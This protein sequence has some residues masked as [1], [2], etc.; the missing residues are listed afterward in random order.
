MHRNFEVSGEVSG[1]DDSL[2]SI[3]VSVFIR[4]ES[5]ET[6]SSITIAVAVTNISSAASISI[7]MSNW[8]P[9]AWADWYV[10]S[11]CS[12]ST[13]DRS[14]NLAIAISA[15][16]MIVSDEITSLVYQTIV[17][18]A[19][20]FTDIFIAAVIESSKSDQ[21]LVL[22]AGWLLAL[23]DITDAVIMWTA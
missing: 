16:L 3:F 6:D 13:R 19:K 11:T 4:V 12:W 7:P 23:V 2:T 20:I 8:L 10:S 22:Q 14:V 5:T 18:T 9:S 1:E 21:T 15:L 17:R